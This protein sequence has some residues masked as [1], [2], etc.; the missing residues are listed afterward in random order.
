MRLGNLASVFPEW[1]ANYAGIILLI[2]IFVNLAAGFVQSTHSLTIPSMRDDLGISYTKAGLLITVAGAIRIGAAFTAGTL[3]PRYGSRYMIG[4]GTIVTGLSML[5]LGAAP[6]YS[7]ALVA[8][9]I[10]GLGSGV[11]LTPM[12][13]LVAPWF[14]LGNRGTVAGLSAAGG[15]IAI[16]VA[17]LVIPPLVS[18]SPEAG[19]RHT[20][21]IFGGLVLAIGFAAV[22]FLRDR[23]VEAS[24]WG[25]QSQRRAPRGA[26]PIGV[27]KNPLVWML[28]Y[29]GFCSGVASGVF[30]TF[31]G[32]YL[33]EDQGVSLGATGQLFLLV[34]VLSIACGI[35]WGNISD[36]L[37]R[38]QAFG[39]SFLIQGI[40]FALFWLSPA[41]AAFILGSILIGLTMRAAFTLCAAASGDYVQ[42]QFASTAFALVSV[43]AGLGST[44]SPIMSGAI[45]DNFD[46]SLVFALGF[47]VSMFGVAGAFFLRR[48]GDAS[49]S[50]S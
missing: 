15:S 30:N 37:G 11:S 13:G 29:L 35:L 18:N 47:G 3:A 22:V 23:P 50:V 48:P 14:A 44:L 7:V 5:L 19:W 9:A 42:A 1:L 34:G 2:G 12:I 38:G 28:A 33:S 43:G 32:S 26:W 8:T 4:A 16:V 36:R 31:F 40:G 21:Y 46:I 45:A 25:N 24:H 27:Y 49:H 10:M 20:W 39:L 17:G 41:M 6:S